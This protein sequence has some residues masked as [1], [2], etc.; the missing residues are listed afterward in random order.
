M[1]RERQPGE[2]ERALAPEPAGE[3]LVDL[4]AAGADPGER[5]AAGVA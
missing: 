5:A 4:G 2:G 3:A 1:D